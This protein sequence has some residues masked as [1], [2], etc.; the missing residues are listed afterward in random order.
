MQA[1]IESF[2]N[3][4]GSHLIGPV[5][6]V[7]LLGTGAFF[8]VYLG[9]P[10][11]RLFGRSLKLLLGMEKSSQKVGDTSPFR[12][13]AIVL[14]GSI[15]AGSIVG[16]SIAVHVGGPGSLFWMWITA[17]L[18]MA[19]RMSEAIASHCYREKSAEGTMVGGPMYTM[20]KGLN[21]RW[22]GVVFA[23]STLITAFLAGNM[24]QVNAMS[25]I[26]Y[27]KWGISKTVTG[28]VISGLVGAVI[29]GGVKRIG[30]VAGL[31]VPLMTFTYLA[32]VTYVMVINY[33]K[34]IPSF[35]S[36]FTC[37]FAPAPAV[38][39]FLGASTS[40]IIIK[41]L[42]VGFFTN[43][44]GVGSS[45]IAHC[46]SQ[47]PSSGKV[48][49]TSMLEPTIATGFMC[50]LTVMAVLVSGSYTDKVFY[51]LDKTSIFVVQGDYTKNVKAL[52]GHMKGDQVL[53]SYTGRLRIVDGKLP[54]NEPVTF[55]H[56][57]GSVENVVIKRTQGGTDILFEGEILVQEGRIISFGD[58]GVVSFHEVTIEG[59]SLVNAQNLALHT[60]SN[61]PLGG[62]MSLLMI[63]C[64][65]LFAFSTVV[66]FSYFGGRA[67]M[68]LGFSRF[69]TVYKILYVLAILLGAV[70]QTTILWSFAVISCAMMAVPNLIS[71][72]LMREKIKERLDNS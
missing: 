40:L 32:L 54:Q 49:I 35:V 3:I 48:G 50:T 67:L 70:S 12:A 16:V 64:L 15:G 29:L 22:L 52:Q 61:N 58:D 26:L 53:S 37:A 18:G 8:T 7:L 39:G 62:V 71:I 34:I 25:G 10:Q 42:Q 27:F 19:T 20:Q 9:F 4:V 65:L 55:L 17:F 24:P 14:A 44:A 13:L 47:E 41:G 1:Y 23:V 63:I 38:G 11:F 72:L 68:F 60:F 21:M 46:A 57:D 56:A 36:V 5:F 28:F 45:A 30:Q 43:E 66:S 51:K 2:I 6:M 59:A 69:L 31:L 33:D